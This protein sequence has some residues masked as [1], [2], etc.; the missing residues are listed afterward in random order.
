MGVINMMQKL[1]EQRSEAWNQAKAFVE[2]H[3]DE[4]GLMSDEDHQTYAQM[5][6]E[7]ENYTR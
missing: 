5:E 7:I 6:A 3:R 1:I 4:K 2:S